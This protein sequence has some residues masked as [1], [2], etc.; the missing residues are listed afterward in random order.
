VVAVEVE[1]IDTIYK[2]DTA[3]FKLKGRDSISISKNPSGLDKKMVKKNQ[4]EWEPEFIS[5]LKN[6]M[7]PLIDSV[8]GEQ[9][10]ASAIIGGLTEEGIIQLK[11]ASRMNVNCY[12]A[13]DLLIKTIMRSNPGLLLLKDGKIIHKWHH[14]QLP[15]AQELREKYLNTAANKIY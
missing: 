11:L 13:D 4:F 14:K 6:K 12:E 15:T 5:I 7:L 2:M 1:R 3:I 9:V 10:G 8:R